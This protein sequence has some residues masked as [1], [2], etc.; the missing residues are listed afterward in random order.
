VGSKSAPTGPSRYTEQLS[1]GSL[2]RRFD[3]AGN[4]IPGVPAHQLLARLG[5][6]VPA[7]PFAGLGAFVETVVQGDFY[8][9]NANLLKAPGY[10]VVN[11]N[12]H[13][14]TELTG[15]YAKRL[16]VYLEIRNV[17]DTT[18]VSSAQNLSNS[19]SGATGLQN[20]AAVLA[21]T[22]GSVF[23]GAPR[24]IVGGMRLSF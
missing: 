9:D 12:L 5:Y 7:G 14:A 13:Y 20:N 1:A 19:I 8:L 4:Q 21:R 2:T 6:D 11:A 22:T 16:S 10:A 3:R 24:N 17:F 15:G 18:Y 23:A